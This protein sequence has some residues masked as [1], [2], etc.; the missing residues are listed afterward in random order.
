MKQNYLIGIGLIGFGIYLLLVKLHFIVAFDFV[1]LISLAFLGGYL[2]RKSTNEGGATGLLLVGSILFGI[3]LSN[4]LG[5]WFGGIPGFGWLTMLDTVFYI[6]IAFLFTW[7]MD[8]SF[9]TTYVKRQ[10]G[11]LFIGFICTFIGGYDAVLSALHLSPQLIRNMFLPAVFI[12]IG[13]SILLGSRK[14]LF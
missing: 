8:Q 9:G 7:L 6:G 5:A 4:H 14:K 3:Y 2:Y 11:F 10:T 12:V 13:I 1:L